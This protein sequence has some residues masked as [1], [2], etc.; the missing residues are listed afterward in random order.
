MKWT[1][2]RRDERNEGVGEIM[3]TGKVKKR[4]DNERKCRARQGRREK[5]AT[6]NEVYV[7]EKGKERRKS[8]RDN[9]IMRTRIGKVRKK[10]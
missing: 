10:G 7:E 4:N 8:R 9:E 1:W 3:R 5:K 2:R 6:S